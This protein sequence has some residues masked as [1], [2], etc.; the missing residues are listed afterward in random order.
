[1]SEFRNWLATGLSRGLWGCLLAAVAPI[2]M[3]QEA[4]TLP[5]GISTTQPA[6]GP[7]VALPDGTFMVPYTQKV[8]SSDIAFEMI[9][10]P[11]GEVVMGSPDDEAQ[12][13]EDEGPQFTVT[14]PAMWVGKT[15][16]TWAEYKT[17]MKC[18]D[19]YKR[20]SRQGIR[21]VTNIDE[22][23]ALTVPTPLYEPSH[24]YEH[25]DNPAQPAVTMTQFAAK[26]YTKWL[27]GITS[28]QYRL[29]SEAE[30][31]YAARAGSKTAY[32]FGDD[33]AELDRYAAFADNAPDGAPKVGSKAPN[34][35]GLHD[36]HGS[37]WEWTIDQY[38]SEGYGDRAG[39]K[40]DLEEAIVWPD[41]PEMRCVRGGGWQDPPERLRS[42]ARMGSADEEW[43]DYDPNVPLS[44]WWYTTDPARMVGMRVV[45]SLEPKS[46]ENIKRYWDLDNESIREDVEYRLKEG[47]GVLGVAVPE[48]TQEFKRKK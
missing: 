19:I 29:P 21:K 7:F 34:A 25:G 37:V 22:A 13:S 8:D 31:E 20:L 30:W 24:T 28:L 46:E 14:I 26:Q 10:I 27:S 3:G 15:E 12:R 47:R 35:F 18:Y 1:M 5:L 6:S 44:P 41:S 11:G 36:M 45:R 43:K 40:L 39:K 2:T 17:F 42:A 23:D 48:L 9:P 4:A 33:P 38:A 16:V 32:S